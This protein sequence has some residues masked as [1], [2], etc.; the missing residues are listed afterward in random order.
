MR[1]FAAALI[2]FG[3]AASYAQAPEVPHKMPFAGMTLTI[4]DD[5]RREIQTDVDALTRSAKH[6]D[7]KCERA[8]TYFP[9][10]KKIFEQEGLPEDF[11]YLAIQESALIPDAVSVSNAVGFWQFKDF[12]AA[13]MGLRVDGEIDERMNIISSTRAAARYL[14]KNNAIFDNWL[15][16]L[17]SYQMGAG[18]TRRSVSEKYFGARH[19]EITGATYW[20][21]KKF[22]AHKIAFE[23]GVEGQPQVVVNEIA[24]SESVSIKEIAK[25]FSVE[26]DQLVAY[27]KW[28]L[29][30]FIPGDKKYVVLIPNNLLNETS[31]GAS[32][33]Q[34]SNSKKQVSDAVTIKKS[35]NGVPAIQALPGERLAQLAARGKVDVSELMTFNDLSID[36]V[37]VPGLYYFLSSKKAT[38]A[39]AFHHLKAGENLWM[40]SQQFGIQLKK[41]RKYNRVRKNE[42][43]KPGAQIWLSTRKPRLMKVTPDMPVL[44]VDSA[45]VLAWNAAPSAAVAASPMPETALQVTIDSLEKKK[46]ILEITGANS[47][48]GETKIITEESVH[49]VQPGETLYNIARQRDVTVM[50][51]VEWNK[52]QLGEPLSVGQTIFITNKVNDPPGKPS[53]IEP[54]VK[55]HEVKASDTLYSVA[56]HYGIT[57]KDLME[58]NGK[59]DFSLHVGEKLRVA[60]R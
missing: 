35:I 42:E 23:N 12:T 34:A 1:F 20:Y 45:N 53:E 38:G 39:Q 7:I 51:L 10:I 50:Q 47:G 57:I 11:K 60:R 29:R 41:L 26:E 6:F 43:P 18:G 8:K 28:A 24:V 37:P 32:A 48:D 31:V 5:A 3:V 22:L 17:Q 30:A 54:V 14:K 21:V 13:E 46:S 33:A 25:K 19:M 59:T 36:H 16:A 27:N 52:L 56:K 58:W 15:Y 40:V 9:I 49:I 4:R 44:E 55:F 2:F